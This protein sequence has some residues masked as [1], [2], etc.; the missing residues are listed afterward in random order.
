MN[1]YQLNLYPQVLVFIYIY[2]LFALSLGC[3][4]NEDST[5]YYLLEIEPQHLEEV[6]SSLQEDDLNFGYKGHVIADLHLFRRLKS[7]Q[8][9][10]HQKVV[11]K[12]QEKTKRRV[13]KMEQQYLQ[14]LL[15][16]V[17]APDCC[18]HR[19]KIR[20]SLL[21]QK[22]RCD[23]LHFL[24]VYKAWEQNYTGKNI[25]ILIV[26]NGVDSTHPDLENNF[27][28][29]L[30]CDPWSRETSCNP[31]IDYLENEDIHHGTKCA[32]LIA[33]EKGNNICGDGV[34]YHATIGAV[35]L[36]NLYGEAFD[37]AIG[38]GLSCKRNKVDIYSCSF[39]YQSEVYENLGTVTK[40][41]L[42][43]GDKQGRN[44]KGSIY[45]FP[46]GNGGSDAHCNLNGYA[47]SI[48]T[49]TIGSVGFD[50]NKATYTEFCPC[51]LATAFGEG[52]DDV[53]SKMITTKI[54]RHD[55]CTGKF[56]GSS[57]SAALASGVIALALEANNNLTSRDIQ[58]LLVRT[59]DTNGT[60]LKADWRTNGAGHIMND[61]F[62]FGL[63]NAS[64]MVWTAKTWTPVDELHICTVNT[65]EIS[66]PNY[67]KDGSIIVTTQVKTDGCNKSVN[68]VMKVEHVE[69]T[70]NFKTD[71]PY[72]LNIVLTSPMKTNSTLMKA[73]HNKSITEMNDKAISWTLMSV[74]F[75]D[76]NPEGT[77]QIMMELESNYSR[78]GLNVYSVQLVLYGTSVNKYNKDPQAPAKNG[79]KES[80]DSGT[81]T[82]FLYGSN[83]WLATSACIIVVSLIIIF[84]FVR[85]VNLNKMEV[86]S[87]ESA[88]TTNVSENDLEKS[89]DSL[90]HIQNPA[91]SL[92][93]VHEEHKSVFGT[94]GDVQDK[95]EM[96]PL[97]RTKKY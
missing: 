87:N 82:D 97:V 50:G 59:S 54:S 46:S 65:T 39:G 73:K 89:E 19:R 83:I 25:R 61:W 67:L 3:K 27:D 45:V 43:E 6:K 47:R 74:Q 7:T 9:Q 34:A 42:T 21:P 51:V 96:V 13:K 17:I 4:L 63:I 2:F 88:Q 41:A 72:Q 95:E 57:V 55:I 14:R 52:G 30:C 36:F 60:L 64:Q 20:R 77:W 48:Y 32:G 53:C 56:K 78:G 81:I 44:G 40:I 24:G 29:S 28:K 91:I 31:H 94:I 84:R 33:G 11:E 80:P 23:H 22:E 37:A 76:E 79:H 12:I 75:W 66:E 1:T 92:D 70:I 18:K 26:D 8:V 15:P 62:G 90:L 49:I 71:F 10:I 86:N 38:I 58:H 5:P 68:E 35:R 16:E 69:V 85:N 93:P